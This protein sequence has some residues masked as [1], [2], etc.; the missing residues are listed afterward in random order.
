MR[1]RPKHRLASLYLFHEAIYDG[2]FGARGP[3]EGRVTQE[4]WQLIVARENSSWASGKGGQA[5]ELIHSIL[6]FIKT[7]ARLKAFVESDDFATILADIECQAASAAIRNSKNAVDARAQIWSAVNH[8]ETA[9]TATLH[10]V[11]ALLSTHTITPDSLTGVLGDK[12]RCYKCML[13]ICYAALGEAQLCKQA[14]A[15]A[16]ERRPEGDGNISLV[17]LPWGIATMLVSSFVILGRHAI[18]PE[19][20]NRYSISDKQ[21]K[22]LENDLLQFIT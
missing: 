14:L 22:S 3:I 15:D 5:M 20:I 9:Y 1:E 7:S 13:A 21:L 6:A 19:Y 17:K 18:D 11:K 10:R 8:L 12:L 4:A 16:W 2:A